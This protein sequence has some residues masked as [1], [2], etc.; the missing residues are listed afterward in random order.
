M[1]PVKGE[2][3]TT[4]PLST[5]QL[6]PGSSIVGNKRLDSFID[7][8]IKIKTVDNEEIIG[9]LFTVDPITSCLA[10]NILFGRFLVVVLNIANQTNLI[11]ILFTAL[12]V[13]NHFILD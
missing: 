12:K 3:S 13:R 10:L 11:L 8:E 6:T 7:S 5:A 9:K 4:S 1:N 2:E